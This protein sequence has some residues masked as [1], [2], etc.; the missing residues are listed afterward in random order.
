MEEA[1]ERLPQFTT[2]GIDH[3]VVQFLYIT[4]WDFRHTA[5]IG[6]Y[7]PQAAGQITIVCMVNGEWVA[8]DGW[9]RK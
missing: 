4:F 5:Q 2:V 8:I 7:G 6:H 9:H 1:S 3:T